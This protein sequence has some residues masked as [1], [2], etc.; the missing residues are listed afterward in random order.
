MSQFP[1]HVYVLGE[2]FRVELVPKLH[3]EDGEELA[4]DTVGFN[5][6]IRINADYDTPRK[7]QILMHEI[8]HAALHVSGPGEVIDDDMEECVVQSL[9][10]ALTQFIKVHGRQLIKAIGT[11]EHK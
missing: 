5:K 7:W 3:D 10:H 6:R 1:D 4:G 9:E 11:E 2:R 8:L